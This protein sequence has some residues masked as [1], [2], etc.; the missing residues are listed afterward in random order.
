MRLYAGNLSYGMDGDG[1][2]EV[3]EAV[4]S[5]EEAVVISDRESGKSKGFGFVD[6]PESDAKKAIAEL[7]GKEVDGRKL[8]VNEARP[9]AE[10]SDR[11]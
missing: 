2:R 10:R 5:V 3:F 9:R 7:N 6:M 4:G 1:L 8:V 11:R